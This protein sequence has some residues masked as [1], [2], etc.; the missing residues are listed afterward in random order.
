[1]GHTLGDGTFLEAGEEAI[2]EAAGGN[3]V[4]GVD[5]EVVGDLTNAYYTVAAVMMMSAI[6]EHVMA[7]ADEDRVIG[8]TET[9]IGDS[10]A[11]TESEM[12]MPGLFVLAAIMMFFQASITVTREIEGG[13]VQ[14]LQVT[15]ASS[16]DLLGGISAWLLVVA[17]VEVLVAFA[18]A[19]AFGFRSEGSLWTAMLAGVITSFSIIGLGMV[20][21]S[22]SKTVSQALVIANFPFA[23]FMS[24]SAA[25]LPVHM[26]KLVTI[27][28]RG[29]GFTDLLP[30]T[31]AATA[32]NKV[33]TWERLSARCCSSLLP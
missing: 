1:V 12:Y 29:F 31:H 21:A 22:F 16:F 9:P 7:S 19:V 27:G 30:P 15:R 33:F 13:R 32:L 11:R 10:A 28:G 8:M 17:A 5:V 14:R 24:L 23:F 18:A 20:V 3:P 2:A 25:A 6:D 26:R 4:T